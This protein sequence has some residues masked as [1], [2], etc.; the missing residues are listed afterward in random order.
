MYFFHI[1]CYSKYSLYLLVSFSLL[2]TVNT[3]F[4]NLK[5]VKSIC[6]YCIGHTKLSSFYFFFFFCFSQLPCLFLL[7]FV[8]LNCHTIFFLG[9]FVI[10]KYHLYFYF[11]FFDFQNHHLYFPLFF[12]HSKLLTLQFSCFIRKYFYFLFV[13]KKLNFVFFYI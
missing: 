11:N 12:H 10:Q 5:T 13:T 6:S 8:I 4:L 2:K 3:I 7:V 1:L 9:F